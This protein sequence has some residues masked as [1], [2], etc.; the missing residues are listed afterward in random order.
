MRIFSWKIKCRGLN[1]V[2]RRIIIDF[3]TKKF[4]SSGNCV[5]LVIKHYYNHEKQYTT[6][7][8][9]SEN[10]LTSLSW[11]LFEING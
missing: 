2:N 4:N 1:F 3:Q 11:N 9:N 7:A 8:N 10:C 5:Y 6:H